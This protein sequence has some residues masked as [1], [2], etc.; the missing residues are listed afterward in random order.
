MSLQSKVFGYF[1]KFEYIFS[2]NWKY[3]VTFEN[4]STFN[5]NRKIV[6]VDGKCNLA[7]S[8]ACLICLLFILLTMCEFIFILFVFS[9]CY[10]VADHSARG[11]TISIRSNLDWFERRNV[12]NYWSV[13]Q[14]CLEM[15]DTVSQKLDP[16]S[17]PCTILN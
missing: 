4:L 3:S 9:H 10:W 6:I 5:R 1:W 7:I 15:L 16:T 17:P 8:V 2:C 12:R 13:D 11:L 14:K